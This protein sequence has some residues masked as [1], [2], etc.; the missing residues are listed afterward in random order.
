MSLISGNHVPDVG[1]SHRTY[2]LGQG[3]PDLWQPAGRD[4][5]GLGYHAVTGFGFLFLCSSSYIL[6]KF[7]IY[8][9]EEHDLVNILKHSTT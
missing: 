1:K 7:Q 6:L 5:T 9:I 3:M 8:Q 2:I 4:V